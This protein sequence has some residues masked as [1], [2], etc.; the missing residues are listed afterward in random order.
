MFVNIGDRIINLDN[1]AY[2]YRNGT[3][4]SFR[5]NYPHHGEMRIILD[6]DGEA[7]VAEMVLIKATR[8]L[9]LKN[10][11]KEV[12]EKANAEIQQ[13]KQKKTSN[14]RRKTTKGDE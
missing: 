8:A 6:T 7:K 5:M 10:K 11:I 4:I 1:V 12:G 3:N 13:K 2:F 14:V 9:D